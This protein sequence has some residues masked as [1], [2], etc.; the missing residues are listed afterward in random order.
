MYIIIAFFARLCIDAGRDRSLLS[1]EKIENLVRCYRKKDFS[2]WEA[3]LFTPGLCRVGGDDERNFVRFNVKMPIDGD[4][5]Q[6]A[7]YCLDYI[8]ILFD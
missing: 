1:M 6:V 7:S 8:Y 3:Q 5:V 2:D 4:L